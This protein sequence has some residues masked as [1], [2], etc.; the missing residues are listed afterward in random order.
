MFPKMGTPRALTSVDQMRRMQV[1]ASVGGECAVQSLL[2]KT[3]EVLTTG[4]SP[5]NATEE[6]KVAMFC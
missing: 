4:S 5:T 2:E 6:G 1:S 3:R